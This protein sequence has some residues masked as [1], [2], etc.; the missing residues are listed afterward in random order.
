MNDHNGSSRR[1][2][3]LMRVVDEI[4]FQANILALNASVETAGAGEDS[5]QF[6]LVAQQ[7]RILALGGVRAVKEAPVPLPHSPS[8]REPSPVGDQG[9]VS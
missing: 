9:R 3:K 8:T 1:V 2:S 7:V 5:R 4:A 6:G